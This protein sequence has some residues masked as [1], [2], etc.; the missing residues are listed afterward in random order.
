MSRAPGR[1]FRKRSRASSQTAWR[2][3][4]REIRDLARDSSAKCSLWIPAFAG[5]TAVRVA[6]RCQNLIPAPKTSRILRPSRLQPGMCCRRPA[7]WRRE[8]RPSRRGLTIRGRPG[9]F[10]PRPWDALLRVPAPLGCK[11]A[12]LSLAGETCAAEAMKD[13]TRGAPEGCP[14]RTR[15]R[16]CGAPRNPRIFAGREF[17]SPAR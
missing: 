11:P 3:A 12:G 10:R 5:M 13:A 2:A 4:H 9:P 6:P 8:R 15:T 16:L 17:A 7:A 14:Q 1:L